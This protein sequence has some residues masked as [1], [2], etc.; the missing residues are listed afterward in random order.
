[1]TPAKDF[2][3]FLLVGLVEGSTVS[4]WDRVGLV[5]TTF[6]A[7]AV[8]LLATDFLLSPNPHTT[9]ANVIGLVRGDQYLAMPGLGLSGTLNVRIEVIEPVTT[10]NPAYIL[11]GNSSEVRLDDVI[12]YPDGSGLLMGGSGI[13]QSSLLAGGSQTLNSFNIHTSTLGM[14]AQGGNE[15]PAGAEVNLTFTPS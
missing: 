7:R 3:V 6:T 5:W 15:L 4:L 2:G 14:L 9:L 12:P 8:P 1:L 10:G 11:S 13:K